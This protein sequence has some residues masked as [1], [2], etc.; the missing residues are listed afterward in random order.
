[1][2]KI[3]LLTA[4]YKFYNQ[5]MPPVAL[6]IISQ[7]LL[8]NNIKHDNDDLYAK[9]YQQQKHEL[10]IMDYPRW[11]RS[12]WYFRA[13]GKPMEKSNYL[14]LDARE[15]NID[16]ITDAIGGWY[17]KNYVEEIEERDFSQLHPILNQYT[18]N[19]LVKLA[20]NLQIKYH[21]L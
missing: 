6:G 12:H 11:E 16:K 2:K 7:H 19:Y 5:F 10:I 9:L 1:M 20:Q 18:M 14:L 4:P 13:I 21:Y 15:Y 3:K 8:D 17:E